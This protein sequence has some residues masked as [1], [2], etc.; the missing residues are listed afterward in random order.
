MVCNQGHRVRAVHFVLVTLI[1]MKCMA[2]FSFG[3][4]FFADAGKIKPGPQSLEI[5][6]VHPFGV[7]MVRCW[8]QAPGRSYEM[9]VIS[10]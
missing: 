5:L 3:G 10:P 9:R 6:P 8:W 1:G 2:F 4:Y 7:A